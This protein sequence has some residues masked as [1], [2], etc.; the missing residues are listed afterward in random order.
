MKRD[1]ITLTEPGPA[2][3]KFPGLTSIWKAL[4]IFQIVA[5]SLL[6]GSVGALQAKEPLVNEDVLTLR[7]T[8]SQEPNGFVRTADVLVPSG[9]GP[10]PVVIIL[11]GMGGDSGF[12]KFI[13]DTT[14]RFNHVICVAPN[15][16]LKGQVVHYK[17]I[18][19]D[20]GLGVDGNKNFSLQAMKIIADFLLE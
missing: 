2:K 6:L 18:G 15:G 16:Y 7:Q 12:A 3:P 13:C 9:E 8:W 14:P 11:H 19:G 10:F 17:L 1:V 5:V 20:H 4:R